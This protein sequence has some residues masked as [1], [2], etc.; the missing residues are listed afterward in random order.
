MGG[1]LPGAA[2]LASLG[3]RLFLGDQQQPAYY[4]LSSLEA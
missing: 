1:R 3:V 2:G 4:R